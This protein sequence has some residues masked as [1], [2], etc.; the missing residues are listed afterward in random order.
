M[1][2]DFA[3]A[4]EYRPD[5]FDRE[6]PVPPMGFSVEGADFV[7]PGASRVSNRILEHRILCELGEHSVEVVA[8]MALEIAIENDIRRAH[9]ALGLSTQARREGFE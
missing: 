4:N 5:A 3:A 2:R 9:R 8:R 6:R 7:G 1:N